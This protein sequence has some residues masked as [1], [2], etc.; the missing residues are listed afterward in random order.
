MYVHVI[1]IRELLLIV[2]LFPQ[3]E[4]LNILFIAL[5]RYADTTQ[6]LCYRNLLNVCENYNLI[7]SHL[8]V[9]SFLFLGKSPNRPISLYLIFHI[10]TH[11]STGNEKS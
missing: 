8:F 6:F 5:V 1:R 11:T 2:R 9:P 4:I 10:Q 7:D 3:S